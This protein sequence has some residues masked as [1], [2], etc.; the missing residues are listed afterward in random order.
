ML[1][2]GPQS[3]DRTRSEAPVHYRLM[4]EYGVDRPLWGDDGLCP[5]GT[6]ELPPHVEEA[7]RAWAAVFQE[8][9]EWDRGW[10]DRAVAREHAAQGE[11]LLAILERVLGPEDTVELVYWETDRRTGRGTGR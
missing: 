8:G 9:F 4:D 2:D 11:R 7:V 3:A 6:P 10:R 5:D 1:G